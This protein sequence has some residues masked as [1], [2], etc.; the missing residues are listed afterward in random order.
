LEPLGIPH[1]NQFVRNQIRLQL[2]L[3]AA[4]A[5]VDCYDSA[6]P[7]FRDA[8]GFASHLAAA[9]TMGFAGSSCIHPS[10]IAAA[11]LAFSPSADAL[12]MARRVVDAAAQAAARGDAVTQLDGKMIDRPFILQAERLL[13]RAARDGSKP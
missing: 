2:R 13:S 12:T 8:A 11:N 1:D 3:A 5:G 6:F 10:Q 7:D 4:E 9:Q